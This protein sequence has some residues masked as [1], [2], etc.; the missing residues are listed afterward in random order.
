MPRDRETHASQ[1]SSLGGPLHDHYSTTYGLNEDSI[2]NDSLYF[3]ITEGLVPDI[4]HDCL[5]G[6]VPY[7]TKEMLKHLFQSSVMSLNRI[8]EILE[9]FPYQG[10]DLRNKPSPISASTMS[11]GDHSLKQTGNFQVD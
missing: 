2:L 7:E 10:P 5:E 4:M 9:A 6:C 11:S 1:I 3:H 8:N